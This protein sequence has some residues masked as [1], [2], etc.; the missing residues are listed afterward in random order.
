MDVVICGD[1]FGL[2]KTVNEAIIEAHTRGSLTH[3][4]IISNAP[5]FEDAVTKA[6]AYGNTL[7]VGVHINLTFGKPL[8]P[9]E[10]LG[11]LINKKGELACGFLRLLFLPLLKDK[12]IVREQAE[13]EIENQILR[14][15][16]NGITITHIDSHR[17]V[18][19]IPWIYRIVEKLAAKYRVLRIRVINESLFYA[20]YTNPTAFL[21]SPLGIVKLIL[22]RSLERLTKQKS[23]RYFFSIVHSCKITA[24]LAGKIKAP[25]QYTSIE[26]MLHPGRSEKEKSRRSPCE[27]RHLTSVYRDKELETAFQIGKLKSSELK[28]QDDNH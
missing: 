3:A 7:K 23:E 8:T 4:S 9:K 14:C 18:H 17:H 22:L 21:L 13:R 25:K 12:P 6:R 2:T 28:T 5:Y 20:L 11:C 19:T 27:R 24:R 1:D 15:R 10:E 16:K 26:I